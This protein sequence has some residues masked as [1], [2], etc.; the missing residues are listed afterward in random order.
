MAII[1]FWSGDKKEAGQ[2]LSMVAIATQMCIEHNMRT[3]MI[4]AT[5]DDDTLERC[6]WKVGR[7]NIARQLNAG[8]IDL[9]S[10]ADGRRSAAAIHIL[11]K[12]GGRREY[13]GIFFKSL[14]AGIHDQRKDADRG[15]IYRSIFQGT[16]DSLRDQHG[17]EHNREMRDQ[18]FCKG[19]AGARRGILLVEL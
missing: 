5:F 19:K 18:N 15:R 12:G 10:G 11:K 2:T 9:A 17:G 7:Q 13:D 14:R 4:D 3:L 8:K 1:S 16:G 6:F